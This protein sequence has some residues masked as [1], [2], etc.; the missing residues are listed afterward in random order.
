MAALDAFIDDRL[1]AGRGWFSRDEAVASGIALSAISTALTR[2]VA[3]GKLAHPRHGFYLIVRPEHRASGAADPAEWIDPLMKHQ[4]LG[5]RVS[6]LRAAAHHGSSH[7]AAMI[8]QV[9]APRQLRD[10]TLG[11]HR[12]QFIYQEPDAFAA[13]NE[14]ALVEAIKTPAGFAVVAGVELTLLDCVR[15]MHRAGGLGSVAQI[16]KDLGA[17]ADPRKLAKAAAHYEGAAVRRLGYLLEREGY[18]K[19]A[20][21]LRVYAD[22]ARH[23]APLDPSVKAV[24]AALA[25]GPKRDRSWK[26]L[27]NEVID[28]DYRSRP[29]AGVPAWR[30]LDPVHRCLAG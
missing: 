24:V 20:R 30:L 6:L 15:Y 12:L 4:C 10:L 25:D 18:N 13:C 5:Y 9:L 2:A 7:Q 27:I 8:F 14:S 21:A 29:I 3:K 26:L 11:A 19:Q 23:V 17:R 16:A 22:S 28:V 1:A